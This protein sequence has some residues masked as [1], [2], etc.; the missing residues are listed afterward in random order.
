MWSFTYHHAISDDPDDW[1]R[2]AHYAEWDAELHAIQTRT[3][4]VGPLSLAEEL[5][6]CPSAA[7][8]K[9]AVQHCEAHINVRPRLQ[10]IYNS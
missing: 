6:K 3:T 7:C 1:E 9:V 2:A 4:E 8:H 10:P 5:F